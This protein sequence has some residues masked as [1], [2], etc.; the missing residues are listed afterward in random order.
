MNSRSLY[1]DCGSAMLS[2]EQGRQCFFELVDA[3]DASMHAP[4]A[5]RGNFGNCACADVEAVTSLRLPPP[6]TIFTAWLDPLASYGHSTCSPSGLLTQSWSVTLLSC[7][8]KA[9]RPRMA[10]ARA[11]VTS[12]VPDQ[13]HSSARTAAPGDPPSGRRGTEQSTPC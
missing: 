2:W 12:R 8:P 5:G 10:M 3:L 4:G 7:R 11:S 13:A 6:T 9:L 1:A